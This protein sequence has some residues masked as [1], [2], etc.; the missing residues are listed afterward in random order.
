[1]GAVDIGVQRGKFVIE[2]ITNETLRRQVIA[3]F[4]LNCPENLIDARETLQ[5]RGMQ[6]QSRKHRF[7]SAQPSRRIFEGDAA[8]HPVHLIS[9][10]EQKF[11][12]VG[13]ILACDTC[14]EGLAPVR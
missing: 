10:G 1:M 14:D 9:L 2:R 3:F 4:R 5:R 11:R 6:V 12:Q 8:N 13:S 7:D